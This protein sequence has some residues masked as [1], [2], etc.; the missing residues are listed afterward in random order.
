MRGRR[1]KCAPRHPSLEGSCDAEEG[2]GG[3]VK[4]HSIAGGDDH[5]RSES[6]ELSMV[7]V[8]EHERGRRSSSGEASHVA[9]RVR[10]MQSVRATMSHKSGIFFLPRKTGRIKG[11]LA[12]GS[13]RCERVKSRSH[14]VTRLCR[15][16]GNLA[17]P[18]ILSFL[19]PPTFSSPRVGR[20]RSGGRDRR[21]EVDL[22]LNKTK[23]IWWQ[24]GAR[25]QVEGKTEAGR[26]GMGSVAEMV[27]DGTATSIS[28]S[29]TE[30]HG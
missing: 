24:E 21:A 26:M 19:P 30:R 17:S 8:Q 20:E 13:P 23:K 2:W 14:R 10:I 27:S 12:A 5:R 1:G 25:L 7:A 18:G 3:G 29:T 28:R 4:N 15:N 22:R 11:G 16:H 6:R 9:S